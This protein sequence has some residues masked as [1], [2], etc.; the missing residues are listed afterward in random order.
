VVSPECAW[1]VGDRLLLVS[2]TDQH[3]QRRFSGSYICNFHLALS[4]V[5]RWAKLHLAHLI[6][7][8]PVRCSRQTLVESNARAPGKLYRHLS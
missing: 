8:M 1:R 6:G 3:S 2:W 5:R 4:R 7:A